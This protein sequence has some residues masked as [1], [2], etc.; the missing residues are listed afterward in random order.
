MESTAGAVEEH[1][2]S[3]A[4]LDLD[5]NG[6]GRFRAGAVTQFGVIHALVLHDIKSRFFGNGWGYFVTILWPG[7][8]IAVLMTIFIVTGRAAPY[9]DSK[10]L[11]IAT[12]VYPYIVWNYISRFTMMGCLMNKA[13]LS[14]P[15]VK[16]LDLMFARV[17]LE[18]NTSFIIVVVLM[19]ILYFTGANVVPTDPLRVVTGIA[20]AI[21][22]GIGF[23]I[24][25]AVFC[26]MWP[27]ANL[28]YVLILILSWATSGVA[29]NPEFLPESIGNLFAWNPLL[30][31]IELVRSG[32]Y[33]DYPTRLLDRT[34]VFALGFVS[35][36]LG[37]I[38]ER[39]LQRLI[40][41]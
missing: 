9:G 3:V 11:Y 10:L 18:L 5:R 4:A 1:D 33:V 24:L 7:A 37:L 12:G 13:Y 16:P 32:Y 38:L 19:I 28:V 21:S 41:Q 36:T 27:L 15:I 14:Y 22:I 39:V 29:I 8:H 20:A 34:Y 6:A 30:H 25:G 17:I 23:G 35:L 31:C 26:M 40:R 2:A